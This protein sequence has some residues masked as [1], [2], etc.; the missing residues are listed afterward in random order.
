MP[1][2]FE[3][4]RSVKFRN[5]RGPLVSRGTRFPFQIAVACWADLLGYGAMIA[6][7]GFNPL[8]PK[9]SE[10]LRRLRRFHEIVASHSS[11][12]FPTLVMND[13]AV[14]YRD[15]SL[16]S[17]APTHDFLM[18]AWNLF[19]SIK[20]E[21]KVSSFPGARMVLATGFRMLG[22]RAG[23][24]ARASHFKSVMHRYQNKNISAEQAIREAANIQQSFDV[25]PRLQANFAFAKAYVAESSGAKGGLAGARFFVDLSLFETPTPA[26]VTKEETVEWVNETLGM[27]VSFAPILDLPAFTQAEIQ[28]AG[29]ARGIRDG[30]QIAEHLTQDPNVLTALRTAQKPT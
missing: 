13:G 20:N 3:G 4:Q 2:L 5:K 7:A 21:E 12:N 25:I 1:E 23:I 26:W 16:R 17:R 11:R 6:E 9:A 18:R 14:A 28:V 19:N 15:L 29:G 10:A 8:H 24:D 30:L 27:R 22:R